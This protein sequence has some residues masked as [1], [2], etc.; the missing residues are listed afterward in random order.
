MAAALLRANPHNA[1]AIAGADHALATCLDA[2][3]YI[4]QWY[5]EGVAQPDNCSFNIS[6]ALAS[7]MSLRSHELTEE[8][9]NL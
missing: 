8:S 6:R 4:V 2:L 3:Q 7:L 9:L 5:E 1:D